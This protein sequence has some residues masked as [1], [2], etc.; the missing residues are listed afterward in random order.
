MRGEKKNNGA[1]PGWA[2]RGRRGLPLVSTLT[3][4]LT[5]GASPVGA[6]AWQFSP[7]LDLA[8]TYTD[9]V[10]LA[11]DDER[12]E[13]VTEISPGFSLVGNGART[14][15]NLNYRLQNL[16]YGSEGS[17]SSH[18]QL[19]ANGNVEVA[20]D[21][22]FVDARSAITQQI[23][24]PS[25]SSPVDNINTGNRATVI[26]YGVSPYFK[27]RAGPYV[28][29]EVRYSADQVV[30]E[31]AATADALSTR[32]SAR[33]NSGR[34]F[35]RL[36]WGMDYFQEDMDRGQSF[37]THRE[38]ASG[39]VRYRLLRSFNALARGG[40]ENNDVPTARGTRNG[41]Y[42]SL[43]GE[44]IANRYLTLSA[45]KGKNYRDANI[46]FQPTVRTHLHVGYRN[47]TVGLNPG[48][49][50]SADLSHQTRRSTWR[51]SYLE[52]TTDIQTLQ[53]ADQQF[54]VVVDPN[55][56][57]IVDPRTGLPLVLVNN[58]FALTNEEFIRKRAQGSVNWNS[59]KSNLLVGVFN[60]RREYQLSDRSEDVVG[61][62]TAWTWR[63]K[64]RTSSLLGASWQRRNP[65]N[66]GA[67]DDLWRV[68]LGLNRAVSTRTTTSIE[69]RHTQRDV[70]GG[71]GYD[72]NRLM[73]RLN[74]RF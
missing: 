6:A 74:M 67:A 34:A 73:A 62:D 24:D 25:V 58:V 72:E 33:F 17:Y 4:V 37:D 23:I 68:S 18:H 2:R 14:K 54:F 42:W 29:G 31:S 45:S 32:Y 13:W 43:G 12:A 9:N 47:R 11:T 49:V 41:S 61:V 56:N 66:T 28:E 60:E 59:G 64:P 27:L 50:W 20:R 55:G 71:P 48:D 51:L 46:D 26:T 36:S 65:P 21:F 5:A 57:L 38:S 40:Y 10:S 30:N 70:A 3:L 44:W 52:D 63:F 8:E 35:T 53:L 15:L 22:F 16:F 39:A 19:N 7:Y 69:L 1:E